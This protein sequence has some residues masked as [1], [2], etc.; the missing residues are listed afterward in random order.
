MK[1]KVLVV[2]DDADMREAMKL[3]V[4]SFGCEAASAANGQQALQMLKSGG[5]YDAV[6]L[7]LM[8]P[9]ISGMQLLEH[10]R[11]TP[12][13][14]RIPVI[15]VTARDSADDIIAGYRCGADY[16]IPKPF[17]MAQ[18][19][20]GLRLV[21]SEEEIDQ[22]AA[23]KKTASAALEVSRDA[24]LLSPHNGPAILS[25]SLSDAEEVGELTWEIP[26]LN[27]MQRG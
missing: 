20:Y 18:L 16:Y 27:V 8:M 1:M 11:S 26:V 23:S 9:D 19:H 25:E 10:L 22:S 24:D 13:T 17:T 21:F 5:C 14:A 6:L 12:V 15:V 7:D 2:D 4:E 3:M